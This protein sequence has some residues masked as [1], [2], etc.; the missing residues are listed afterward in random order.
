MDLGIAQG[1]A[2]QKRPELFEP[3]PGFQGAWQRA[4]EIA[5]IHVPPGARPV[6]SKKTQRLVTEGKCTG[7]LTL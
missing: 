7:C 2:K 4:L 6:M 1:E 3:K 5:P